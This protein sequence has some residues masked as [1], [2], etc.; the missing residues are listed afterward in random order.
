[1]KRKL[2]GNPVAKNLNLVNTPKVFTDR[3]KASKGGYQ[4]HKSGKNFGGSCG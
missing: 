3:K 4:K 1:M 2:E